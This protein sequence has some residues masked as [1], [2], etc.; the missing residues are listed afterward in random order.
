[1]QVWSNGENP[2]FLG[3]M[4]LYEISSSQREGS[5]FTVP[6][7]GQ[8]LNLVVRKLSVRFVD[9]EPGNTDSMIA[10]LSAFFRKHHVPS[11]P[12]T[13]RDFE[14]GATLYM[15]LAVAISLD[16][17][18]LLFESD[19]FIPFDDVTDPDY[20]RERLGNVLTGGGAVGAEPLTYV[21]KTTSPFLSSG[22]I[23]GSTVSSIIGSTVS[24]SLGST[25]TTAAVWPTTTT[26][27]ALPTV[28]TATYIPGLYGTYKDDK[29]D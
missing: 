27:T 25:M 19:E 16:A 10:R 15:W 20:V 11:H 5:Y 14:T 24:S 3:E 2:V 12:E 9:K 23:I 1:M 7:E 8:Y 29:T 22:S 6:V 17:Y 13:Q 28:S 4:P 18:E 21:S 26:T